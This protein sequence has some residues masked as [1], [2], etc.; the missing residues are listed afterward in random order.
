MK[1][2]YIGPNVVCPMAS[3]T[4]SDT[5]VRYVN[6]LKFLDSADTCEILNPK[7]VIGESKSCP[8]YLVEEKQ[9]WAKGFQR[10]F[11]TIPHGNTYHFWMISPYHSETSYCRA[12][13][14]A[15]LIDPDMQA[16]LLEVLKKQGADVSIGF[17]EYVE[18]EVYVK[19]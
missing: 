15:I 3:C 5:C 16:R 18:Q 1:E 12:K 19:K 7:L 8:C 2:K 4:H 9:L 6:Y 11:N 10:M 17:D 13:R 14:G